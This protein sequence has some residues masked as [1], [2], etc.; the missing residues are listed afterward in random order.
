MKNIFPFFAAL[1][2]IITT[3]GWVAGGLPRFKSYY[4]YYYLLND[5]WF[6]QEFKDEESF[7][8]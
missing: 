3:L 4:Y 7:V 2:R 1:A 8:N 6:V 5:E